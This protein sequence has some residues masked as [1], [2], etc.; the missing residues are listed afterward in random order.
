LRTGILLIDYPDRPGLVA[1]IA[2]SLHA[3][4][5]NILHADQHQDNEGGKCRILFYEN[6][7]VVFD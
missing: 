2:Q 7:T 4:G 5:G 6:K 3:H 1:A